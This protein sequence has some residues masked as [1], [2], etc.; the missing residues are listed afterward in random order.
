MKNADNLKDLPEDVKLDVKKAVEILKKGGCREIYI[1]GS[2][3]ESRVHPI[4]DIDFA[5]KGCPPQE[6]Y[7]LQ[8]KL[9]VE[10]N[11]SSDLIDLD[12]DTDLASF[13]EREAVLVNVG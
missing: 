13:L 5:V 12:S 6:F 9:L 8:G 11:R 1:F 10:L 2:L 7:K 4:S 3:T